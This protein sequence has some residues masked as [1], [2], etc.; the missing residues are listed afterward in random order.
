MRSFILEETSNYYLNSTRLQTAAWQ[1]VLEALVH[2]T[3][4]K[5]TDQQVVRKM[6][7]L[8]C[9]CYIKKRTFDAAVGEAACGVFKKQCVFACG[10]GRKIHRK[11]TGLVSGMR[12]LKCK[13]LSILANTHWVFAGEVILLKCLQF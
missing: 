10:G 2:E 13:R 3:Q 6:N 7:N 9:K 1:R 4:S 12:G 5:T 11:F 8:Y